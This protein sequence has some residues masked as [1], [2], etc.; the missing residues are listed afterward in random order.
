[1]IDQHK[2]KDTSSKSTPTPA[3]FNSH[4]LPNFP[5]KDKTEPYLNPIQPNTS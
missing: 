4:Q 1:M 3:N 5:K 2:F